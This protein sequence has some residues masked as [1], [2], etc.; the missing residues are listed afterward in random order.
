MAVSKLLQLMA[1]VVPGAEIG[2]AMAAVFGN[3]I[4]ILQISFIIL[5]IEL[6]NEIFVFCWS[7]GFPGSF[8]NHMHILDMFDSDLFERH[9][10][11]FWMFIGKCLT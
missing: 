9:V 6:V 1:P 8:V 2:K 11:G 7:I 10:I 4:H 3:F 5:T